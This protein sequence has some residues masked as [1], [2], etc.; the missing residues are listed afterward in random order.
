VNVNA[1]AAQANNFVENFFMTSTIK[2][3]TFSIIKT[4]VAEA[5][6]SHHNI[7]VVVAE[8]ELKLPVAQARQSQWLEQN[9]DAFTV[10][11]AWHKGHGHPLADIMSG[12]G[13]ST[14][15]V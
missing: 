10:Q 9:A 14:W 4:G 2:R 5:G 3:K 6:R 13:R 1:L 8:E 7:L 12:P 15:G 11:A